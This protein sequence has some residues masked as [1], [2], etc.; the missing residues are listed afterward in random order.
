M[1]TAEYQAS[2]PEHPLLRLPTR[3][4][5]R[6]VSAT[7]WMLW[8]LIAAATI[9]RI[10]TINNQSLWTD[11]ALTAYESGLP[12]GSMVHV[13]LNIETTPPLYFLVAWG[14]SLIHI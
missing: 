5:I 6:A 12:F 2:R 3:E 1:S 13:M 11:E 10:L 7:T 14:L 9:V 4:E 8:G